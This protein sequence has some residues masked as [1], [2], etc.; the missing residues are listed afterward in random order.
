MSALGQEVSAAEKLLMVL[1]WKFLK[2]VSM[3]LTVC[4]WVHQ[5]V[6]IYQI[7]VKNLSIWNKIIE[8]QPTLIKNLSAI[9]WSVKILS[10]T[11]QNSIEKLLKRSQWFLKDIVEDVFENYDD[12]HFHTV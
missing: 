12:D 6:K 11:H 9:C 2:S 8:S 7:F 3:L 5:E 4:I 10:M 1:G